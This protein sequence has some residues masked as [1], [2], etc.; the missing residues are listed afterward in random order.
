MFAP[1]YA[2]YAK[3]SRVSVEPISAD[4]DS[5][6]DGLDSYGDPDSSQSPTSYHGKRTID[7]F[8]KYSG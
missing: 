7:H 3:R 5:Y 4:L 8:Y 1:T 6:D 2:G